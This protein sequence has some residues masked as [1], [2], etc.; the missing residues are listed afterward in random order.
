MA[1][2]PPASDIDETKLRVTRPKKVAVGVPAV[3]HALLMA[4]DLNARIVTL[5][6]ANKA[7]VPAYNVI[8][9]KGALLSPLAQR[10]LS[11][12]EAEILHAD[13]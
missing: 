13:A 8:L 7:S 9:N 11:L 4:D 10:F 12:I 2:K 6:M 5:D 3:V 1:T